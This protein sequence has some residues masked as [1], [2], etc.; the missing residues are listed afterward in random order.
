MGAGT[1]AR[2]VAGG[3]GVGVCSV[4]VAAGAG[5]G[6]ADRG[7]AV[8]GWAAPVA[9]GTGVATTTGSEVASRMGEA[10][11]KTAPEVGVGNGVGGGGGGSA[12]QAARAKKTM[13]TRAMA[14][15]EGR[16]IGKLET[17]EC[18]VRIFAGDDCI[19]ILSFWSSVAGGGQGVVRWHPG[20]SHERVNCHSELAEES[21]LLPT[22]WLS[23]P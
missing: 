11:G 4:A 23:D 9:V 12:T 8:G 10:V 7:V 15:R 18:E 1:G 2:G 14:K 20:L 17:S 6:L 3:T 5:V 22:N 16:G 19:T 13:P 21:K